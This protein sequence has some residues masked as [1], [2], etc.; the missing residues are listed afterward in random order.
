MAL[1]FSQ[2][3]GGLDSFLM[4]LVSDGEYMLEDIFGADHSHIVSGEV[5]GPADPRHVASIGPLRLLWDSSPQTYVVGRAPD[6]DLLL[7]EH[8]D[9]AGWKH[10]ELG[11]SGRNVTIKDL[12]S[13]NGTWVNCKRLYDGEL[14]V[15]RHGDLI[16]LSP[17]PLLKRA[18]ESKNELPNSFNG[19][20]PLELQIRY[21]SRD[22][23]VHRGL[24]GVG[25][26]VR[27][28][29]DELENIR[30]KLE[31]IRAGL[32]PRGKSGNTDLQV[33]P[34]YRAGRDRREINYT[35]RP[36]TPIFVPPPAL[37]LE[38]TWPELFVKL[39][40]PDLDAPWDEAKA[41][42]RP[43]RDEFFDVQ[44]IHDPDAP[45]MDHPD[46]IFRNCVVVNEDVN[47]HVPPE[48]LRWSN[49]YCLPLGLHRG[50]PDFSSVPYGPRL[51]ASV[52]QP[53]HF[54]GSARRHFVPVASRLFADEKSANSPTKRKRSDEDGGEPSAV[55]RRQTRTRSG[56]TTSMR[57][58]QPVLG[59][60]VKDTGTS[61][62][63]KPTQLR[64]GEHSRSVQEHGPPPKPV[65][66]AD[67]TAVISHRRP[68]KRKRDASE[69]GD[70]PSVPINKNLN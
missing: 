65:Q 3:Y 69:S 44:I 41:L 63:R 4:G 13:T 56:V 40:V 66:D 27:D 31:R 39:V 16:H 43:R 15:L 1:T 68:V 54:A 45:P 38:E 55:K 48:L 35:D 7:P 47:V 32:K 18:G 22:D 58:H 21:H 30:L 53:H 17:D 24:S 14:R 51:P 8:S 25:C 9:Y 62:S 59:I 42:R 23:L 64:R 37:P 33:I 57:A 10:C 60:K 12:A 46:I 49:R 70:Q 61:N 36:Q 26:V 6:C 19:I 2:V 50:W 20:S 5:S 52:A 11:W 28:C 34:S 67:A 29:L